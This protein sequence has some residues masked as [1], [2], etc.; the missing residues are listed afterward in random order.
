MYST[1]LIL[2]NLIRKLYEIRI[3][4]KDLSKVVIG[5]NI[6]PFVPLVSLNK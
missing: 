3:A 4:L 2:E 6:A 5:L 1:I